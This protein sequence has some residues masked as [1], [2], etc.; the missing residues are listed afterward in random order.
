MKSLKLI[1]LVLVVMAT[2]LFAQTDSTSKQAGPKQQAKLSVKKGQ[3]FYYSVGSVVEV[4]SEQIQMETTTTTTFSAKV[5]EV[6]KDGGANFLVTC[7]TIKGALESPLMGEFEFDSSSDEEDENPM[8]AMLTKGLMA[9]AGKTATVT[10]DSLGRATKTVKA[11]E[12]SNTPAGGLMGL[13][14]TSASFDSIFTPVLKA[15]PKGGVS[16]GASWKSDSKA[17]GNEGTPV[18]FSQKGKVTLASAT[19]K[20]LVYKA[21]AK[22]E[23]SGEVSDEEAGVEAGVE[24]QGGKV[25]ITSTIDR[26]TGLQKAL[27]QTIDMDMFIDSPMGEMEMTFITKNEMKQVKSLNLPKKSGTTDGGTTD[28]G[29]TDG[30]KKPATDQPKKKKL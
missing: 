7:H 18:E 22:P 5:L 3:T 11:E 23:M 13:T 20:D 16:V 29:T 27:K 14:G 2:A 17:G 30:G 6:T 21:T 4:D 12:A 24:V 10:V 25:S 15:M 26:K 19:L 28:G 9:L 8:S 1:P